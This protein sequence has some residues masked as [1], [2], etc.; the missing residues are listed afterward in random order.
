VKANEYV[1]G[2]R[3][4]NDRIVEALEMAIFKVV[5]QKPITPQAYQLTS[6]F[7][8]NN[9][10]VQMSQ[11][12][13]TGFVRFYS[14]EE[15]V[16][17]RLTQ[18]DHYLV[19]DFNEFSVGNMHETK[20][21]V[22]LKRDS[23]ITGTTTVSGKSQNVYGTVKADFTTFK[24]EVSAQGT[25]SVKIINAV[26]NRVEENRNFP[27]K[28]VWVNEWASYNGDDRA[29]TDRQKQMAKNEPAM[30]PPQ[31]DLFIEFTKPIFN[32]T[33]SFVR[34]YYNKLK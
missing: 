27:G 31:Q 28:Y 7:F 22:E 5:V 21:T 2:Y 26:N 6:D 12:T 15:A 20:S 19:L 8:Y 23:V 17:E 10:M 9:L 32:Q 16:N 24:R 18:P 14:E 3:N 34:T 33:V 25:L 30:P 4:V 1:G 29:L 11:T 13:A